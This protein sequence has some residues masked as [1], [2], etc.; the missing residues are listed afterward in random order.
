MSKK[1]FNFLGKIIYW[2]NCLFAFLLLVSFVLPYL[3]PSTFPSLS[4]WSLVVSPLILVN[5]IFALYWL[6]RLKRKF[7]LSFILLVIAYFHFH[8]FFELSSEG[9]PSA[10]DNTLNVLSYN[11]R[12]FNAYEAD[13]SEN[14]S[15]IVSKIIEEQQPDVFCVQEFYRDSIADFS[16]FPYKYVHFKNGKVKLGHAVFSKYPIVNQG[17][18]DF[19][20]S[21]NN[22]LF[23]D[24]LKGSDT[25]RVYNLHLQSLGILP[26][27]GYLQEGD[28]DRL[29]KRMS[30][31]FI[32]QE[33]QVNAIMKHKNESP[34]PVVITGDFNNTSFSYCYRRLKKGMKDGFIERGSA[35]G[36][37]Y[38][39]D[40]YP[41]R[42]DYIL[43]SDTMDVVS[44][45]TLGESFSDHYP[46]RATLGW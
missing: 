14:V 19:K 35:L 27:V 30:R 6:V 21:F 33:K 1:K 13:N 5:L 45:E 26:T 12:L 37:T 23:V 7:W 42:I 32:K 29:R 41:M 39:F 11:V 15:E 31:A 16:S 3:K 4:L 34:Y 9:D 36:T 28:K 40:G 17:A 20:D 10:Y 44:F 46:I 22:T 8:P 43:A 25:L 38:D 2:S 18:F 24:I